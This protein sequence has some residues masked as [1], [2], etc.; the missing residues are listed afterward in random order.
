[1]RTFSTVGDVFTDLD[2]A[3]P[4]SAH[5][6]GNGGLDESHKDSIGFLIMP[7]RPYTSP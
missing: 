1:M 4:G 7:R 6:W 3:A 2:F 5:L